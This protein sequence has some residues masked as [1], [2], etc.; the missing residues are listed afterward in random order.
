MWSAYGDVL[1]AEEI[2]MVIPLGSGLCILE[3]VQR[4]ITSISRNYTFS[5]LL[6]NRKRKTERSFAARREVAMLNAQKDFK[7]R[8][9]DAEHEFRHDLRQ[10]DKGRIIVGG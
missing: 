8:K 5:N 1:V 4:D 2:P 7:S 9:A 6:R 10:A 3:K